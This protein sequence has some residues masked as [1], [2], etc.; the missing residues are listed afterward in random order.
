MHRPASW[1]YS[2]DCDAT[3]RNGSHAMMGEVDTGVFVCLNSSKRLIGS[4]RLEQADF[5]L[6]TS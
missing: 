4:A 1:R 5:V 6:E 2:F 3:I